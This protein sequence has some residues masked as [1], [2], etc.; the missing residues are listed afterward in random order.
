MNKTEWILYIY[1]NCNQKK[2]E[3]HFS[4]KNYYVCIEK[5]IFRI[6]F[7]EEQTIVEINKFLVMVQ[8]YVYYFQKK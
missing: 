7:I 4:A 3:P 5:E 2:N 6:K 1:F 8:L